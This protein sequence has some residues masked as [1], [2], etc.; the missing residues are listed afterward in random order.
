MSVKNPFTPTTPL[1]RTT[2]VTPVRRR[3]L[4]TAA[5]TAVLA[6]ALAACG[7]SEDS[8]SGHTSMPGMDHS[9]SAAPGGG[10]FNDADVTFAQQMIPHHRQALEMA[11]LADGRAADPEVKSL[12]AAVE[13]A[14]DPE[15]STMNGWLSAWG[16]PRPTAGSSQ[17]EG[18]DMPGMDHSSG[19]GMAGMMSDQDMDDLEAARG[20]D[21]DKKFARLMTAHHEGAIAMAEDERKHGENADAKKLAADVIKGQSAE[22]TRMK[23][24][25]DRL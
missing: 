8:G 3:A 11:R 19:S 2:P 13:K 22:I 20:K 23:K 1:T 25:L 15:I 12:A 10:A 14:Q 6:L 18:G 24:I 16:E 21:F 7:S 9:A 5:A 17:H 4:A